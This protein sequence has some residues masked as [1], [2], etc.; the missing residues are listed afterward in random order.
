MHPRIWTSSIIVFLCALAFI[1]YES[2][3]VSLSSW[4]RALTVH[5]VYTIVILW[6]NSQT[7]R[8]MNP[9]SRDRIFRSIVIRIG[10]FT[11]FPI[12]ALL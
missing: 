11:V 10:V 9:H 12:I 4:Q 5:K 7:F 1:T 6:K 8:A 2:M 3:I